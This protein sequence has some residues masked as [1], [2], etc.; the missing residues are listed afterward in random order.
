[1][2]N[3][4]IFNIFPHFF[5]K[6]GVACFMILKT[7]V[8]QTSRSYFQSSI[9]IESRLFFFPVHPQFTKTSKPF[10]QTWAKLAKNLSTESWSVMSTC[11]GVAVTLSNLAFNSLA[12]SIFFSKSWLKRDSSWYKIK[13]RCLK[14]LILVKLN[15]IQ[16]L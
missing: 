2:L 7:P 13:R 5:F 11:I 16:F 15:L 10:G 3:Y 8:R 6:N 1:M 9:E 14:S 4:E 12:N